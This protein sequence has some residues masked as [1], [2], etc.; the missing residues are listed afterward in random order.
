VK[1]KESVPQ[2]RSRGEGRRPGRNHSSLLPPHSFLLLASCFL[3]PTSYFLLL[4]SCYTYR[5]LPGPAPAVGTRVELELTDQGSRALADEVG[6]GTERLRGTVVHADTAALELAVRAVENARGEPSDWSGEPVQ[7]PRR[8][9]E[10]IQERRL[11]V[12]GTGILGGAVAASLIAA[13]AF[14]GGGSTSQGPLGGGTGG[15]GR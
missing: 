12:G 9:V 6:P 15:A 8:Y 14:F 5:P 11:S 10:R 2:E 3:L 13:Y 4:T 7:I 1:S